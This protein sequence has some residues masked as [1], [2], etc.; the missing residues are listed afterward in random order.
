MPGLVRTQN[1]T[2]SSPSGPSFS[3]DDFG[4]EL[5]ALELE[6]LQF[7][8]HRLVELLRGASARRRQGFGGGAIARRRFLR[9][10]LELCQLL[11]AGIDQREFGI[12]TL[13]QRGE[14]ID[15]HIVFA[16]GGAQREQ[17]FLD[18]LELLRIVIGD[19]QGMFEMLPR[20]FECIE[21]R[22]DRLHHRLDQSRH[23]R[24]AALEAAHGGGKRWHRRIRSGDA[25]MS[26][27][28]ILAD[29]FRLHHGGAALGERRFLAC[30][31]GEF[32]ELVDGMAQPFGFT[33]RALDRGAM[34]GDGRLARAAFDP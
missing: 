32:A 10:A 28:Q 5:R 1:S 17:A 13:R 21:R 11:G 4:R 31:R 29:F 16:P 7:G 30:L 14:I 26:G 20:V 12:V 34:F 8:I 18:A 6:R 25:V 24:G 33:C 9:F 19:P 27:A 3:L 23:L 15:R 22:I 2:R